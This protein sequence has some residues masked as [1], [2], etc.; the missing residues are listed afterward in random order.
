MNL[1]PDQIRLREKS[2]EDKLVQVFHD[3]S[4]M[5]KYSMYDGKEIAIQ[6]LDEP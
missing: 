4:I 3:D 6:I 2:G 1:I 5:E